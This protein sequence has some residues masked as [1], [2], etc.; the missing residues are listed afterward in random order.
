MN[1]FKEA[2]GQRVNINRCVTTDSVSDIQ[3]SQRFMLKKCSP[4]LEHY[5]KLMNALWGLP[6]NW[7][8]RRPT[9]VRGK[10]FASSSAEVIIVGKKSCSSILAFKKTG[11]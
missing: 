1:V 5:R 7:V 11:N 10:V 6:G 3:S 4:P 8:T 2:V 9:T